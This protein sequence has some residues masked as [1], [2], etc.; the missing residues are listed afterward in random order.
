MGIF[1]VDFGVLDV[2]KSRVRVYDVQGKQIFAGEN[3]TGNSSNLVLISLEKF[4]NGI[5]LLEIETEKG[6]ILKRLVKK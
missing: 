5:Y 2:S 3:I 6:R 4:A 1:N